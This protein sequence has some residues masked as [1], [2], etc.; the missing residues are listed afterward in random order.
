MNL[1]W[2]LLP[3]LAVIAAGYA[4]VGHGGASGFLAVLAFWGFSSPMIKT[5]SLL[6]NLLV[7][8]LAVSQFGLAGRIPW[9]LVWPFVITSIP[10]AW[11]GGSLTL[12]GV[13]YKALLGLFLL[14]SAGRL[15]L[16]D[17]PEQATASPRSLPL[18]LALPTGGLIGI[19]AGSIGVGGGVF[20]SPLLILARWTDARGAAGATSVFTVAN[21]A[22]A[23]VGNV[24]SGST[25]LAPGI[26]SW[27]AAALLGGWIGSRL[28]S[29]HIQ[30]Q[31]LKRV[32]AV[33]LVLAGLRLFVQVF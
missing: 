27:V 18:I 8:L 16:P 26:L 33:I 17:N 9:S 1:D 25:V 14:L 31:T 23:L 21:S 11:V 22:G 30:N 4:L 24:C 15:F 7:G 20:L 28:G 5:S 2:F 32:L 29:R 3:T 6:L 12:P 13:W 10:L 19:A